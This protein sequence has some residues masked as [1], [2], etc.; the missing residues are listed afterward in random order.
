MA[1]KK[2]SKNKTVRDWAS[3][4]SLFMKVPKQPEIVIEE[5]KPEEKKTD[6]NYFKTGTSKNEFHDKNNIIII[7]DEAPPE[8]TCPFCEDIRP[9]IFFPLDISRKIWHLTDELDTEWVGVLRG[10]QEGED[11]IIT[12]MLIPKQTN[13]TAHTQAD[14]A[15]EG[16]NIIGWIHSHNSMGVFF[17]GEDSETNGTIPVGVVVNKRHDSKA[18]ATFV[19]QCGRELKYDADCIFEDEPNDEMNNWFESIKEKLCEPVVTAGW[20]KP[21]KAII[22]EDPSEWPTGKAEANKQYAMLHS[23][24]EKEWQD[25]EKERDG[26]SAKDQDTEKQDLRDYCH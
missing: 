21:K 23:M 18:V 25:Y 11:Y 17:S 3:E 26:F 13:T 2:K 6:C 15:L 16:D 4:A 10:E 20:V 19:T 22:Q 8:K 1:K 12:D 7:D 5:D 9:S 14:E 24:S